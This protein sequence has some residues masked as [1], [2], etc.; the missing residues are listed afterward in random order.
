MT[1]AELRNISSFLFPTLV[2]LKKKA[3]D[4]KARY[5]RINM[6]TPQ[7]QQSDITFELVAVKAPAMLFVDPVC[8]IFFCDVL[9]CAHVHV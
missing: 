4:V 3:A 5:I 8:L 9:V 1:M 6:T 7:F 2:D